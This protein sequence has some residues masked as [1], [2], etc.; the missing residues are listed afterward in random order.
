MI[1]RPKLKQSWLFG[2]SAW[3]EI[4]G[5]LNYISKVLESNETLS[6]FLSGLCKLDGIL[7]TTIPWKDWK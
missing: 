2:L 7:L 4:F 6:K 3:Y 5:Q 1:L